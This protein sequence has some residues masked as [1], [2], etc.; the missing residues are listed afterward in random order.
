MP[1]RLARGTRLNAGEADTR[2]A[3]MHVSALHALHVL[4]L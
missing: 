1:G 4:G 3:T 2:H